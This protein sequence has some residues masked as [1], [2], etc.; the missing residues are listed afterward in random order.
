MILKGHNFLQ[1]KKTVLLF[2]SFFAVTNLLSADEIEVEPR[3]RKMDCIVPVST[4]ESVTKRI[5]SLLRGRN[6]TEKMIGRSATYFPIFDKYL[7]EYDLP[8]DLKYITCLETELNNKTVSSAGATGIWQLMNDVRQEFGLRIDG[9]VD[10]RLDIA[11]AT[12]A[13]LKDLK[14]LFKANN[15]W[16][17]ALAGYNCGAGRLGQAIK[18][19]KSND[20]EKVKKFLP[21]QTQN[22]IPKFIAF[23]YIMKNYREHGLHPQLPSLDVQC[24]SSEKVYQSLSLQTVAKITGVTY[25]LIKEL[26]KQFGDGFVPENTT[27]YN[28]FV[29][30]RVMG[31]LHDYVSNPDMQRESN[32]NFQPIAVD[33]TLPHLESDPNYFQTSYFLG[34]DETLDSA[35]ELFNIGTYNIMIWNALSTPKVP[36]GTELMLYLPRVVPKKV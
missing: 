21:E 10:E 3:L 7:R 14:R 1:M 8:S 20:F 5:K 13:A 16:E 30:Q 4:D 22:Y 25:E 29:P 24:I 32:L 26:N 33:E 31:A 23:T 36:K 34:E 9:Q 28:V 2:L 27:G 6:D 15:S 35:A 11:R 17:M 12:E 19:A 18:R